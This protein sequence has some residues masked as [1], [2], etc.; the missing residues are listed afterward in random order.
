[1][2]PP[3]VSNTL[4]LIAGNGQF[5]LLFAQAARAKNMRIMA[6][7]M[8][9]ETLPTLK[10]WV[11][12]LHWV[13]VG[14]L[15]RMITLF[16]KAGITHVA[17]AGGLSK[18]RFFSKVRL[19]WCAL[20]ILTQHALRHDDTLLRA[21]AAEFERHGI[22]IVDSTLVMPEALA[23]LGVLTHTQPSEEEW[24]DIHTGFALA[25]A[26]GRL[27]IGQTVVMKDGVAVAV[28]AIEGTDACIARAGQLTA[29]TGGVVVKTAKPI[30]DMRFDVPAVGLKTLQSLA[31]AGIRV[32]ALEAHRTLML[33]P[34]A[35]IQ[36]ANE[37]GLVIVGIESPS[38]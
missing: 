30:Q 8:L 26:I 16:K 28:E 2:T 33:E 5:P 11:D 37:Q 6:V 25:H 32:L 24:K 3:D 9:Q 20:K 35:M 7:G 15:G 19:D 27:D 38:P 14:Q 34:Q 31:Q 22:T 4:G 18:T 10:P 29:H 12:T 17:M 36:Q 13:H 23:P 21:I 1:M